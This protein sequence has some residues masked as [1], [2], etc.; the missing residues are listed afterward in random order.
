MEILKR[1]KVECPKTERDV[2]LTFS[3][4]ETTTLDSPQREGIVGLLQNCS[5]CA[6]AGLTVCANCPR[7]AELINLPVNIK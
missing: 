1:W 4:I 5:L 7:A 3:I 6:E 2:Y